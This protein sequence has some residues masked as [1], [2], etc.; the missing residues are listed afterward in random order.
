MNISGIYGCFMTSLFSALILSQVLTC[1]RKPRIWFYSVRALYPEI[2]ACD[3]RYPFKDDNFAS[4]VSKWCNFVLVYLW[5]PNRGCFWG[6]SNIRQSQAIY[7]VR[8]FIR[9]REFKLICVVDTPYL[10]VL[11]KSFPSYSVS[12]SIFDSDSNSTQCNVCKQMLWSLFRCHCL[13][14][15]SLSSVGLTFL[16]LALPSLYLLDLG[17]ELFV[18]VRATSQNVSDYDLFDLL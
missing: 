16:K 13:L 2:H 15:L 1:P 7:S 6:P 5:P 14:F 3:W 4:T 8:K 17:F 10:T 9:Q 18:A 11:L 12:W